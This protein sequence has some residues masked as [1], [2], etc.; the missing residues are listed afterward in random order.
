MQNT[1]WVKCPLIAAS[2]AFLLTKDDGGGQFLKKPF[3]K[4]HG[5]C[6]YECLQPPRREFKVCHV[7]GGGRTYAF[8]LPLFSEIF[9]TGSDYWSSEGLKKKNKSSLEKQRLKKD[10]LKQETRK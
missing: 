3:S 2:D 4:R 10:Q 8:D 1:R 9:F 6:Q 7:C 5:K